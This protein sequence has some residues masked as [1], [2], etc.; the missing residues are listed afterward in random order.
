MV[1]D[2]QDLLEMMSKLLEREHGFV[3]ALSNGKEAERALESKEFDVIILDWDLP[4]VSGLD[5]CKGYRA[6]GG[7]APILMLTGKKAIDEKELAFEAGADD[8]LTKPFNPRELSVRVRALLRRSTA[9]P[10]TVAAVG[11]ELP[12]GAVLAERF[13][14]VSVLGRGSMGT[15][16]KARH[17]GLGRIVA[18]KVLHAQL[19]A[20][21]AKQARFRMEAQAVSALNH[22][23]VVSVY[24]F[25][26]AQSG[27]PYMAMEFLDGPTLAQII[28][29]ERRL[30]PER[31]VAIMLQACDALAHAHSQG[32]V[33][34]DVKPS[35]LIL[36]KVDSLEV[37]KIVDFGIAKLLDSES[38]QQLTQTGETIG[39]PLY[40]SP[41]QVMGRKIDPRTDIFSLACVLYEV[42]TGL[43]PFRGE[44]L[45][46]T[47]L[48]RV[49][50]NAPTFA[51]VRP[52]LTLPK[53]LEE[54][55]LKALARDANDRYQSMVEFRQA[56]ERVL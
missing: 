48:K 3:E 28:R 1:E 12:V 56:L 14:I 52:D 40:M 10:P 49:Q 6:R 25:G 54:V 51:E 45:M 16:Y 41:E 36:L 27:Q 29:S 55:T 24:D 35:N 8:Y 19:I 31:A 39:S 4:G 17:I 7:A 32:V 2:Y 43:Q 47:M 13:E 37:L 9:A 23:Y 18:L 44:N 20:E 21:K 26:I 50:E 38:A 11:A 46:E 53:A 22:P 42:L 30:K 33:H 34:R 15:V 5:L